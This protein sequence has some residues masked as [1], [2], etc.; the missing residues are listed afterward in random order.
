MAGNRLTTYVGP[1][2]KRVLV[3]QIDFDRQ[4]ATVVEGGQVRPI[5]VPI[6]ITRAR[7]QCPAVGETWIIDRSLGS[8]WTFAALVGPAEAPVET[9]VVLTGTGSP[10]GVVTAPVGTLYTRKDGGAGTTLYVKETGSG[11]T[12]WVAK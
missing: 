1:S 7:G 2:L 8:T 10:Q 11:S 9:A 4:V 3:T 12:G 5:V 6:G